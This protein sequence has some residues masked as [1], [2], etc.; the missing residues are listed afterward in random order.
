MGT[1]PILGSPSQSS[2]ALIMTSGNT[3]I[4]GGVIIEGPGRMEAGESGLN[5]Q[6]DDHGY[7]AVRSLADAAII[8]NSWREIQAGQ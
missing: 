2:S 7:D 5:I 3:L 6:F 1:P 8:Q 4:R